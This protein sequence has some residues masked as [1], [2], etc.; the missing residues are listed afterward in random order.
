[1]IT[2]YSTRICPRCAE[3]KAALTRIGLSHQS[4]NLEDP[5]TIVYLRCDRECYEVEAP[6]I[7]ADGRIIPARELFIGGKLDEKKLQELLC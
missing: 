7:E 3:L 6:I 4:A 1:M 5:E 2:V